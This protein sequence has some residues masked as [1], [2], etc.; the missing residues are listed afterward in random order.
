MHIDV[1]NNHPIKM[2]P[3][4]T[5]IKNRE[6]IDKAVDE[7]LDAD[8][9]R[10]SR[11]PWS[12]P[13]VI[14]DKK[15]GSKR[16]CVDF[17]KLNQ[18]TKKNSYPLPLIDDILALLGK[19]KYFTSLDLKSG[20]W[21][22]AMD[23]QDKEKTAFACHKGLFE[24]NV[25]PFGL[26][27]APAVF[28]ELMSVV[29]QG[30]SNFATAY[31]DDI[32]IFSATLEEHLEH[33]S[34]VFERLREHQLKLKLKK[35]SFLKG[36]TH[37]LG[38]VISE[39][40]IQPDQKKVE[41]IRT[42]PAPTCVREVRSFIGMCSYYRRFI[43]NF[44]KIAEPIVTLTRKYAHFKWSDVH[45]K[46]FEFLKDSLTSVPLLVYPDSKKPYTLFT[47]ASDTCIGACLTQECDGDLKPIYYLSHKLSRSQC[48][49]SVVEKEAYAIHFALQKLDYYLHNAQFVIKTDHKPLK[50]L[51]E[52]PMQNKK[53]QMWALSM[54]GY[55][56]SIEYIEG[57]TNTCAD[58]LSRHPDKINETQNSEEEIEL[59]Q[60]MLDVNNNLF[61]INV[62][63]SNQFD[64]KSFA[65]CN[66]P[67]EESFEKCDCSDFEKNGF[68]MKV[69]QSKDDDLLEIR[70]MILNG[71][72]SKDVQKHYLLVDGLVYFISNVN[73]D[74]NLRLYIPKHIRSYVVTQ[75]HDQNGHMGVQ[76]TFDSIR[77]KYYWPNLF[78]ELNKYV[79]ECTI[80]QTRSLQK[81]SQPLHE[82][83][84]PPYPMAKL[85]LDLSG[86]YPTTLS[87]NKYIIAFVD[88]FS[89]WPEAFAVPDK[90]ADTVAQLIIEEIF[91]RHGCALQIVSDNGTENVN[92]IVKETLAKLKIDHVLTSVYH[93]QSNAKV[94]RFHRTLHDVL[95][96]KIADNQQTWDL[97]L[98]Q[99][100]AAIRFNVSESSRFSPF[101]LLYN[102]DV[103]LPIDN[104][105]KPRRKYLGEELH[106]TALQA[107]HKSFVAVRN[108]LRKAKK[109]QAK[110]ADRG[111]KSIEFKVGDPVY[112]K[113]NQRKGKLDLKW[114]P[115]YRILEKTGP[116]SY[117]IKN[118]L[119]GSTSKVHAEMLRLANIAD[120]QISKDENCRR[121]RDAAY[122]IPP[123][124]SD[125][126]SSS[127]S[128][129]ESNLPLA[130]LAKRYR[131]E[132][133]TSEDEEDIPLLELRNR[134]R[135]RDRN[136]GQD[137]EMEGQ[138]EGFDGQND[139]DNAMDVNE[140]Q[141]F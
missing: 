30:Y 120:W 7:M 103:V 41:A 49:W 85:S 50:Y 108:H 86:P 138:D 111:T 52:S 42:L 3:Y 75:Y 66:L 44:S 127:D 37:Y 1:G 132:R 64:P 28:Q 129:S 60:T 58:L 104:I 89:G 73:D 94:E 19:S 54:S 91:P 122:V 65:S 92:R 119:D 32:M 12:F 96:K 11:S 76:K 55:N 107:Q 113:N 78:K 36:E 31:L 16:F 100:L 121:L 47:D 48:K 39:D 62:L 95:A 9:I 109:R 69:E 102:R 81:I 10:R 116:V 63:D 93:P 45:Q 34:M 90:T 13:V 24:F 17:R 128:D 106:Q 56:C 135:H 87:G 59:D 35:C 97:F 124:P 98:N 136:Q 68:D 25:M 114:K 14:V 123:A 117:V 46:A 137:V 101:F 134:L 33:L 2:R 26:S 133:E 20:Y 67:D 83:D 8:V 38:F 57:T 23:E 72:E 130:K 43:P 131:H 51:L 70:S 5:P 126:D 110:Y 125:S 88:W 141:S 84:I 99:A 27:N 74:P 4:R 112:Y 6:V 18:I 139:S 82:T 29:L 71:K 40:G 22:V 53:I 77:A 115:Y 80:C 140:I 105:L 61:E 79:S 118:Q 21:Q 15:D